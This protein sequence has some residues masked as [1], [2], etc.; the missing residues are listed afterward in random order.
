L[1]GIIKT[2]KKNTEAG[3]DIRKE[4]GLKENYLVLLIIA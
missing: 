1:G 3:L 2:T 4:A